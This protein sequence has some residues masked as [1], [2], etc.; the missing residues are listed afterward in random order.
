MMALYTL[1]LLFMYM[2]SGGIAI[3][4][5]FLVKWIG[6]YSNKNAYLC[7]ES[8]H[9]DYLRLD[10]NNNLSLSVTKSSLS[11]HTGM[12]IE[13]ANILPVVTLQP[14]PLLPATAPSLE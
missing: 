9:N 1:K 14:V 5:L 3:S 4:G 12:Y 13:G 2:E 6:S 8:F 11:G 10:H 7:R